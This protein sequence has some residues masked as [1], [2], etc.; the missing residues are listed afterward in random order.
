MNTTMNEQTEP[1]NTEQQK[2]RNQMNEDESPTPRTY[3]LRKMLWKNNWQDSYMK[4]MKHAN[5]LE[6]ELSK[7]T[8]HRDAAMA[9]LRLEKANHEHELTEAVVLCQWA[10]P[11]LLAMCHDFTSES[12]GSLCAEKMVDH[13]HIFNQPETTETK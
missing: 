1:I 13:P 6:R 11:R 10:F 9:T 3:G 12:T 4:M 7:M 5:T 2:H 8:E